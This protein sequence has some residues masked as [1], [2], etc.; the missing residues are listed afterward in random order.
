[1]VARKQHSSGNEQTKMAKPNPIIFFLIT[2]S[3]ISSA[4]ATEEG[5]IGKKG[6]TIPS[7]SNLR[8]HN[9]SEVTADVMFNTAGTMDISATQGGDY[10]G[11]GTHFIGRWTNSTGEGVSVSEFGWPCGGFWVASWYVW[12]SE[13][14]PGAPG[15]QDFKGSFLAASEDETEYPP[16]LY[17]YV[18]VANEGIEIPAGSTMYFGYSNPGM[19]GQ[20]TTNG[21]ET[22]SWYDGIWD[23][24]SAYNRTAVLQFKGNFISTSGVE[25]DVKAMRTIPVA[26]PNP[27]NPR[28]TLSF[29]LPT[30]CR[31]D[32]TIHDLRGHLVKTLISG[33]LESGHHAIIWD[34]TDNQGMAQGSGTYFVRLNSL[35]GMKQSKLALVR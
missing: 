14:L 4:I 24:D 26:S 29:E 2:F 23:S 11:W 22:W 1:M 13:T 21:V 15:T 32:L 19:G 27:F 6:E 18:D 5:L 3:L 30:S 28:T 16:S 34:G 12:I 10:E 8:F 35:N 33:S 7:S 20:I 17:T 25:D 31:V 9:S